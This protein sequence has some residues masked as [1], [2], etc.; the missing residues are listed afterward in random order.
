MVDEIQTDIV[1][2]GA[3][4]VGACCALSLLER[5]HTV[6]LVDRQQPGEAASFGNAG[7]ISPWSFIPQSVPGIWKSIPGMLLKRNGPLSVRRSFWPKMIP[8]GLRFLAKS[9][10]SATRDI[11]D[12]MEILCQPSVSLFQ[13]HLHK[14][15]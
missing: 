15:S 13:K 2:L 14:E 4:I 7:V 8:W 10:E 11:A 9:S 5:G 3:G 6:T 1:V 12:A